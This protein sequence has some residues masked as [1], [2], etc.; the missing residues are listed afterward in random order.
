M[1]ASRTCIVRMQLLILSVSRSSIIQGREV[2]VAEEHPP[3]DRP[4]DGAYYESPRGF[5]LFCFRFFLSTLLTPGRL[6]P[7]HFAR[8]GC[9]Y[10]I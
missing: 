5:F 1:H 2:V 9:L 8:L 7:A 10:G 4:F 3:V 6:K